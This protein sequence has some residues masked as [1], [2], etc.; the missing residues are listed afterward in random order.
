MLTPFGFLMLVRMDRSW[1]Q[2]IELPQIKGVSD[3]DNLFLP[4]RAASH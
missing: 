1:T 2:P 4:L 3:S